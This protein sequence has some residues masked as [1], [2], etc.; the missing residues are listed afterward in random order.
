[1]TA[2]KTNPL[3]EEIDHELA[4]IGEVAMTMAGD[5]RTEPIPPTT[6]L[7]KVLLDVA[8]IRNKLTGI[9][10]QFEGART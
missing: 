3:V 8:E 7:A 5:I 1:M 6:A 4:T 10:E 2:T 9:A